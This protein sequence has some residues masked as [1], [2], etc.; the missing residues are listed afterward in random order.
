MRTG[1]FCGL[2]AACLFAAPI[3]L[4]ADQGSYTYSGGSFTAGKV[5]GQSIALKNVPLSSNGARLSFTCPIATYAIGTYETRWTCANGSV[6]VTSADSSLKFQGRFVSATMILTESAGGRGSHAS[7]SYQFNGSISGT[8]SVKGVSQSAY[9]GLAQLVQLAAPMSSAAV[10]VTGGAWGWSSACRPLLVADNARGRI[11]RADSIMGA[12]FS[13]YGSPGIGSGQFATI[14]GIATDAANRIYLTDSTLNRVVRINDMGGT[15][16][17]ELGSAG[18]GANHFIAPSGIAI[19]PSGRIWI[20]D[21]GNNR[22]VRIDD[23]NGTNWRSIG[24]LGSGAEQFNHPG[25]IAVDASGRVYVADTGN[26]RVVRFDDPTGRNWTTLAEVTSGSY[27]YP[28]SAP[29]SVALGPAGRIFVAT[30]G[31]SGYLVSVD[32]MLGAHAMLSTWSNA[33]ASVSADKAGT[34]YVS[35]DFSPGLA[36]M[37]DALQTGYFPSA[38]G[39]KL[40]RPGPVHAL[41]SPAPVPADAVLTATSVSFGAEAVGKTSPARSIVLANIGAES[42]SIHAIEA[43]PEYVVTH[44]CPAT[45]RGGS[46]CTIQITFVPGVAG[47]QTSRLT[48]SSSGVHPTLSV[49]L[50]GTGL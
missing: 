26:N 27:G 40:T 13:A 7:Y 33:L 19:G 35:G 1:R 21:T 10:K 20:A 36:Q 25:G 8:V 32:N 5:A 2:V 12:N 18:T 29:Q 30:G 16:W 15:N 23:L 44:N 9:G 45:L 38:L 6:S 22:I 46:A 48:V 39:G 3:L 49:A 37:N 17:T 24:T 43:G 14:A 42:L 47:V 28:L 4:F 31:V 34:L 41:P 11:T 50:S